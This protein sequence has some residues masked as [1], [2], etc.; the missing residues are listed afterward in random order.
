LTPADACL[1]MSERPKPTVEEQNEWYE[2][3]KRGF[4]WVTD[5][6]QFISSRIGHQIA[7]DRQGYASWL[8]MRACVTASS[9]VRLFEPHHAGTVDYI[10]HPSLNALS[11]ALIENIATCIY[12]G[13]ETLNEDEWNARRLIMMVN[14]R[15]NRQIFLRQIGQLRG[16]ASQDVLNE[17]KAE[18]EA[19]PVFQD[20]TRDRHGKILNGSNMFIHGR[21]NALLVFGWGDEVTAGVYKFLS[22]HAHT[23]AFSFL[24]TEVN[25]VYEADSTASKVAAGFA[26]DHARMALGTGCRHMVQLFPYVEATF[27]DLV[28]SSLARDYA[29]PVRQSREVHIEEK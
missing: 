22:S 24:R 12:F 2:T 17:M 5:Q 3:R 15:V 11:R 9:I 23:T 25:R 10:D 13:D 14:D 26:I 19:N 1:I 8:W 16:E 29:P 18:L 21:H 7:N 4:A 20:F 27:N 6:A 28:W